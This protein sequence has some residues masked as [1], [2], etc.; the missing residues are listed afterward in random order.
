MTTVR[1]KTGRELEL[2]GELLTLIETLYRELSMREELKGS[3]EDVMREISSVVDQMTP[4][5]EKAYLVESLFLNYVTY[6]N[7]MLDAY[8]RKLAAAADKAAKRDRG[9]GRTAKRRP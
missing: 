1:L 8:M 6:E 4:N 7:E 3:F 2:D 5:E 9:E